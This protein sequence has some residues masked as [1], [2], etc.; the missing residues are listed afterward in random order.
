M[1]RWEGVWVALTVWGVGDKVVDR[2]KVSALLF[3]RRGDALLV[4]LLHA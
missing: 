1:S 2:S 3:Y 4:I